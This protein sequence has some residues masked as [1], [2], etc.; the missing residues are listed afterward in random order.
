MRPTLR[1][2]SVAE[3]R[4]VDRR[5]LADYGMSGLVLMENAGR[6]ATDLLEA[7]GIRGLVLV[8]CGPGNNGGDGLVIARHLDLRGYATRVL[9]WGDETKFSAD[10]QA[11]LRIARRAQ[12]D[13]RL[14]GQQ[15]GGI[16]LTDSAGQADW[17]VDAL[18]G[19]GSTGNPRSPLNEVI[20]LLNTSR[21]RRLAIDLPS[22]LDA[23]TGVPGDPTF[24]A[25][26]TCT[27]VARKRGFDHPAA[28]ALLGTVHV[29]DIGVPRR[30]LEELQANVSPPAA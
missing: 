27:M 1:P 24:C 5:A 12:L 7:L 15:S 14:L 20:R 4:D 3:A 26:H 8:C 13:C 2:L 22:G 16:E 30:L 9:V 28:A 19:T 29:V 6:A 10:L 23:D 25:D 18:L 21:A 17:I 11:N